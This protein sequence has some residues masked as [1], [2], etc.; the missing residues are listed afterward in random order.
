MRYGLRVGNDLSLE[1]E[2]VTSVKLIAADRKEISRVVW[3]FVG[4][5]VNRL[6]VQLT[7]CHADENPSQSTPS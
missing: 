1:V 7:E 4:S 6:W 5:T 3:T 2:I